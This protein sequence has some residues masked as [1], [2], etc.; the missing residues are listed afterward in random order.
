M[1]VGGTQ[2]PPRVSSADRDEV[3]GKSRAGSGRVPSGGP[4]G[5]APLKLMAF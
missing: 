4:G 3:L 1:T 5:K 2:M